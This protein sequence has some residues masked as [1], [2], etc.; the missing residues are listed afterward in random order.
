MSD[1]NDKLIIVSETLRRIGQNF[2]AKRLSETEAVSFPMKNGVMTVIINRD[3]IREIVKEVSTMHPNF[4]NLIKEKD[5]MIAVKSMIN[6]QID[7]FL[8]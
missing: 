4:L 3:K 2:L 1:D 8:V 5:I 7:I 6:E